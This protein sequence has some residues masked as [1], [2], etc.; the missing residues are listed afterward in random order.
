MA[1]DHASTPLISL[2]A[3]VA[4]DGTIGDG[5]AIPWRIPGEQKYFRSI[6]TGH[7]IIM[8]RKT[9]ESIGRVLPGRRNMVV[10]R[11]P[12]YRAEGCEVFPSLESALAACRS[13]NEVFVIGGGELYRAGLPLADRLYLTEIHADFAGDTRFPGFDRSRWKLVSR[14]PNRSEN[15]W[16][17]DYAVYQRA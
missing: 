5:N 17:Y 4:R 15:G 2:I 12:G 11:D 14:E 8:G 13:A 6:T 7:P 1:L 9:H 16:A 3:A 10:S